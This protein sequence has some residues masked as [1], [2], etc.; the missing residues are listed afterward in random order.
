MQDSTKQQHTCRMDDWAKTYY[1]IVTFVYVLL[2]ASLSNLIYY[3]VCTIPGA[4]CPS[5]DNDQTYEK[6]ADKQYAY[7]D[8]FNTSVIVF[9]I[10]YIIGIVLYSVYSCVDR[11]RNPNREKIEN[12]TEIN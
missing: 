1:T 11:V 10:I 7:F 6:L 2:L 12:Y 8:K 5:L 3:T 9:L 4:H